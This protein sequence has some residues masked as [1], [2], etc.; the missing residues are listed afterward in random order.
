MCTAFLL[1]LLDMIQLRLKRLSFG[2]HG[3]PMQV[4][5][6]MPCAQVFS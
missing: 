4:G 5:G 1:L 3:L 6:V 2:P